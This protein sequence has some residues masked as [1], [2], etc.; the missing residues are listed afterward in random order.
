MISAFVLIL[1]LVIAPLDAY[2]VIRQEPVYSAYDIVWDANDA[3]IRAAKS[4]GLDQVR[5]NVVQNW[6]GLGEIGSD[7]TYWENICVNQY[8]GIKV[9]GEFAK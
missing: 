4:A 1:Y 8:Y 3:Q 7:S 5:I 2:K 9:T 6:A